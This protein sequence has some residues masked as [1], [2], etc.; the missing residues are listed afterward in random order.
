MAIAVKDIATSAE[1]WGQRASGAATEYATNAAQAGEAWARNTAAAVDNYRAGISQG[2]VPQ[3]YARGVAKAGQSGKYSRKISTVGQSRYSEGVTN[4]TGDWATGFGPYH[5]TIA[6][7]SLPP[8]RP[9]GDAANYE[10][11]KAIGQ[12]LHAKRI[13]MLGASG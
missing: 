5:Q 8:R 6:S 1:K 13:A 11:G 9:R 12:A 3:R 7:V 10:R 2:N 4:A